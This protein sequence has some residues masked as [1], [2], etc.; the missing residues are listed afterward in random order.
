[1]QQ[2]F[3]VQCL[4]HSIFHLVANCIKEVSMEFKITQTAAAKLTPKLF[5]IASFFINFTIPKCKNSLEQFTHIIF[6]LFFVF[7]SEKK[8]F[9]L[10]QLTG[11]E[12]LICRRIICRQQNCF[13]VKVKYFLPSLI[14]YIQHSFTE[15]GKFPFTP[16]SF[17]SH[18]VY[19]IE[20]SDYN[21]GKN[22]LLC[23]AAFSR[24]TCGGTVS[25]LSVTE[26]SCICM[27]TSINQLQNRKLSTDEHHQCSSELSNVPRQLC[28]KK[29]EGRTV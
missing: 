19:Q 1:M 20:V 29:T 3:T 22:W 14:S 23:S 12:S 21:T 4:I 28:Y 5:Y 7:L 18:L 24:L 17:H 16:C 6:Q 27:L 8:P 26:N 25:K 15:R 11:L 13:C 10:V 2:N 9:Y